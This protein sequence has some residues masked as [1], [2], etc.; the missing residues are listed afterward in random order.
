M[1]SAMNWLVILLAVI[2]V[3]GAVWLLIVTAKKAPEDADATATTGHS[4]DG[5][6]VEYN[7][8]LP[9]WTDASSVAREQLGDESLAGALIAN[10]EGTAW[11][12]RMAP[13]SQ[14]ALSLMP[15][16]EHGLSPAAATTR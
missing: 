3:V 15:V 7:K 8:P 11:Q 10:D 4:W 2:N 9:R 5:D 13:T 16:D 1:S 14:I 6:L 12:L